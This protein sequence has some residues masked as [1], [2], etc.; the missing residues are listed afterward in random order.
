MILIISSVFLIIGIMLSD[1]DNEIRS[2]IG[3]MTVVFV[4]LIGFLALGCKWPVKTVPQNQ[5]ILR[6]SKGAYTVI[7]E[8]G[9]GQSLT[10]SDARIY[11]ADTSDIVI[12]HLIQYNSYGMKIG[13]KKDIAIINKTNTS[14]DITT[15]Q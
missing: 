8:Y 4:I 2:N 3:I 11:N 5:E 7:A 9:D 13:D 12:V 6:V 15:L 10:S 14:K 1:S